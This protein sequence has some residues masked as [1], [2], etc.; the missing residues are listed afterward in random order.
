VNKE[1]SKLWA[2]HYGA[3]FLAFPAISVRFSVV[4]IFNCYA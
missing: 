3:H 1:L 2:C 4:V